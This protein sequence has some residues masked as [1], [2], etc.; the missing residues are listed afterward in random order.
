M[1][2][3]SLLS[4][5]ILTALGLSSVTA[6]ERAFA[7][8]APAGIEL[9]QAQAAVVPGLFSVSF[10]EGQ[11]GGECWI[12]HLVSVT[13]GDGIYHLIDDSADWG[14]EA[15]QTGDLLDADWLQ[16]VN[17]NLLVQEGP[18]DGS[19]LP[20]YYYPAYAETG[21]AWIDD[22][23]NLIR[24]EG[25]VTRAFSPSGS[26]LLVPDAEFAVSSAGTDVVFKATRTGNLS[27]NLDYTLVVI[28]NTGD[29]AA[30]KVELIKNSNGN[31]VGEFEDSVV[32]VT[33]G[34]LIDDTRT[35]KFLSPIN[36]GQTYTLKVSAES[37]VLSNGPN[38][39][40]R[41]IIN[42]LSAGGRFRSIKDVHVVPIKD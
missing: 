35:H 10:I 36:S 13:T 32:A 29:T 27:I 22:S 9:E 42:Q 18:A 33:D 3:L 8:S 17:T 30:I 1:K 40:A 21:I 14:I 31:V 11:A 39:S 41:A 2:Y 24:V 38:T 15:W 19:S 25:I 23:K 7:S 26:E 28:G 12:Q 16:G 6:G 34:T 5:L 37:T 4:L 20:W